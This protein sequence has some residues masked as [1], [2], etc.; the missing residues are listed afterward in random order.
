[1]LRKILALENTKKIICSLT[2]RLVFIT[3]L[4][5][6]TLF[7][8]L[9]TLQNNQ[10][11]NKIFNATRT[12]TSFQLKLFIKQSTDFSG[13][14]FIEGLQ[15]QLLISRNRFGKILIPNFL[16][17]DRNIVYTNYENFPLSASE[18]S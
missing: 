10:L 9:C 11:K 6:E 16:I 5:N 8:S 3:E 13:K 12:S 1:M 7:C 14:A 15:N 17:I 2:K 18:P 4:L